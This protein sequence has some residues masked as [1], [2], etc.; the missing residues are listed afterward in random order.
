MTELGSTMDSL[1]PSVVS[2]LTELVTIESISSLPD[3]ADRVDESAAEVARRITE[4]GCPDVR[5]V[6]AGGSCPAV[7]AKFPA[8]QGMPTVLLYAHHDVQPTGELEAWS[9]PPFEAT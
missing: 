7:I 4:I 2:E 5:V 9:T 8:P 1:W 3:H 6:T